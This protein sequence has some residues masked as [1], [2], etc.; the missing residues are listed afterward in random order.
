MTELEKATYLKLCGWVCYRNGSNWWLKE[1]LGH[2]L[3]LDAAI[4]Y[5]LT[6]KRVRSNDK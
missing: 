1:G 2:Y 5:Q 6:G 3:R 4:T